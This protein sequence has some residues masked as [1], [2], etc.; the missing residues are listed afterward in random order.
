MN[1]KEETC[2]LDSTATVDNFLLKI[3][4]D[5]VVRSIVD[6]LTSREKYIS[7]IYFYDAVGSKLFERIT[8]LP[9]YY[10][11]RTEKSLLGEAAFYIC[12]ELKD[13]DIVELGSGDCSKISILLEAIPP[14]FLRSV[15]YIPVDVSQSVVEESVAILVSTFPGMSIHGVVADFM[16]QL[17]LIPKGLRRFF[18]FLGSTVGNLSKRDAIGFFRILG[19]TMRAGDMLLLGADMVKSRDV[20]E[21]AYNDSEGVTAEF[22]LNILNV[23][24][25][26]A[27]TNFRPEAFEHVAFYNEEFSRIEMHLKAKEGVEVESPFIKGKIIIRKG[28]SIHTENSHK[29]THEYIKDFALAAGLEIQHIFSDEREWFSLILL[30]KRTRGMR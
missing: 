26:I 21:R 23:V 16:K 29:F 22:N 6:G 18:C 7:C 27:S 19:E 2:L 1:F 5:A 3:G 11:A 9:E 10:L 17:D 8:R 20:L 24:N 13:I 30:A 25:N 28:E 12:N 15:R 14:H 4:R